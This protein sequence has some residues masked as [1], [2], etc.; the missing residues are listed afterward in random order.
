MSGRANGFTLVELLIVMVLIATLSAIAVPQMIGTR[1]RVLLATMRHDLRNLTT[2]QEAYFADFQRYSGNMSS[3]TV[4]YRP[5]TNVQ[6][7]L[8]NAT[9]TG[10]DAQAAH[11]QTALT[12]SISYNHGTGSGVPT[13]P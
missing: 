7:T 11:L 4:G 6:I 9:G 1:E 8:G 5:T 13:C 2:A 10:W 3:F 12:C